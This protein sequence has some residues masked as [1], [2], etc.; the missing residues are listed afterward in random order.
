ML[1]LG[2]CH[3]FTGRPDD[4]YCYHPGPGILPVWASD[5]FGALLTVLIFGACAFVIWRT[6]RR[7]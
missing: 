6:C 3:G 4:P 5:L 1:T 7:G 2:R